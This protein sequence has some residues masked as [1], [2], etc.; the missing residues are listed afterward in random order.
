M[1]QLV[2]G[3]GF[4]GGKIHAPAQS[5]RKDGSLP[6]WKAKPRIVENEQFRSEDKR[7]G[8]HN[9]LALARRQGGAALADNAQEA[10]RK[11]IGFR[12]GRCSA[13]AYESLMP[14]WPQ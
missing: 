7:S 1:H 9:A 2:R 14:A 10:L 11:E 3:F 4:P 13:A 8:K 6:R 12:I 5:C